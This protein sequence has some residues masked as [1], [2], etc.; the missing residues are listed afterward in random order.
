VS[1]WVEVSGDA[2][3]SGVSR[4]RMD[5]ES[6]GVAAQLE[7]IDLAPS[8]TITKEGIAPRVVVPPQPSRASTGGAPCDGTLWRRSRGSEAHWCDQ[9]IKDSDASATIAGARSLVGRSSWWLLSGERQRQ[10][11]IWRPSMRPDRRVKAYLGPR[12]GFGGL[13]TNN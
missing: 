8:S 11:S 7:F 13:M 10:L 12:V 6:A 1:S 3:E 5:P 2:G 4:S 9:I